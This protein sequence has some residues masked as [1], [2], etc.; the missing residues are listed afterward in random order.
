[1]FNTGDDRF[2]HT[3]PPP[4]LAALAGMDLDATYGGQGITAGALLTLA[5]LALAGQGAFGAP[6]GEITFAL[7]SLNDGFDE[8]KLLFSCE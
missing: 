3:I 7:G 8:C 4:I 5:N 1:M 2:V 6:L